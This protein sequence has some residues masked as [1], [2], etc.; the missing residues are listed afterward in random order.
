[1]NY[2]EMKQ[3]AT[4]SSGIAKLLEIVDTRNAEILKTRQEYLTNRNEIGVG[5]FVLD[6]EKVLRVAH[7]WG[8]SLQLTDG[9]FGE[10]FY[11]G[12]GHV[13]FSGGL[14]PAIPIERFVATDEM[15]EGACWFF[16]ENHVRAHNGVHTQAQFHVWRLIPQTQSNAVTCGGHDGKPTISGQ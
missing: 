7:H 10:S 1:M 12:N 15:R 11:L 5:D 13:S 16:S 3:T 4:F 2:R 6:G 14:D 8:D 9:R